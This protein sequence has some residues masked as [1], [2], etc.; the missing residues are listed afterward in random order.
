V[1]AHGVPKI[2]SSRHNFYLYFVYR[3][4]MRSWMSSK[5]QLRIGAD[6]VGANMKIT[7][8]GILAS[9]AFFGSAKPLPIVIF[10]S[11]KNEDRLFSRLFSLKTHFRVLNCE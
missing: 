11:V 6:A 7:G 3:V 10:N 4:P 1:I 2:S 5:T 9:C 8:A